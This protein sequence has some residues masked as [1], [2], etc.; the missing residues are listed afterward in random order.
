MHART[1]TTATPASTGCRTIRSSPRAL[2][3][4]AVGLAV[5]GCQ[6][7]EAPAG[8]GPGHPPPGGDPVAASDTAASMAA[9][10]WKGETLRV[11]RFTDGAFLERGWF[12]GPRGRLEAGG[13]PTSGGDARHF[14]CHFPPGASVCADGTPGRLAFDDTE[15]VYL[16]YH[17]RYDPG[18]VGSGRPYHPH[19]FLLT[20]NIDDRFIGPARTHLTVYVEQNGGRPFIGLQDNL[21]VDPGCILRNDD[22][23]VGCGGGRLEDWPFGESRSVAACNGLVGEVDGRD[24]Y[25][26]GPGSWYS[27]RAWSASRSALGEPAPPGSDGWR[28]VEAAV[29]L[30][31]LEGGIGVPDGRIR[32]WVD[33][34]LLVA[35]DRVLFRTG[36][37]PDMRFRNLL[38]APYIGDGSPVDQRMRIANL[39]VARALSP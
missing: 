6:V 9:A 19:E 38:L 26:T 4:L 17:V 29:V 13:P 18:W 39:V 30:N 14:V 33:G 34:E 27:S 24:C 3:L 10:A 15:G 12:D 5:A 35:S 21:N 11:E 36:S 31:R 25:P 32:L 16:A 37:H 23:L 28:R 8:P 20:T 22:Q 2:L 7:E 1:P